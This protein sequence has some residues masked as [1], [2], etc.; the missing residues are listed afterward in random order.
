MLTPAFALLATLAL[1]AN[2]SASAIAPL[3]TT[4]DL[5]TGY[6]LLPGAGGSVDGVTGVYSGIAPHVA[7]AFDKS[8]VTPIDIRIPGGSH[9]DSFTQYTLANGPFQVGYR[10]D[11]GGALPFGMNVPTFEPTL[12]GWGLGAGSPVSDLNVHG[13]VVGTSLTPASLG[14][15]VGTTYAAFSDPNGQSHGFGAS[16]VDNLNNY[17]QTIP[18]VTL[19]SALLIDDVGRI[20][21]QG[22]DGHDY[23][24]T[25]LTSGDPT[26]TPEPT[27]LALLAVAS[28]GYLA[29][30]RLRGA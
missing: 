8:P 9:A 15:P 14:L 2:A 23:L 25:P 10:Y 6:N 12:N 19:T 24:L 22:S 20:I 13:Q 11:Y 27:T 18:G 5:G 29:R 1:A 21:A 17:I 3:Y 28:L 30:R 16:V 7:Y 4:T 26:P